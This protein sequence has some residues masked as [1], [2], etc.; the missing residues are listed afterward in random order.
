M[1]DM[2]G[3]GLPFVIIISSFCF[4]VLLLSLS[5]YLLSYLNIFCFNFCFHY[6]FLYY[7]FS[8]CSWDFIYVWAFT[9]YLELTF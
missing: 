1:F 2:V 8:V 7:Y 6:I 3:F 5:W 9:V 4:F